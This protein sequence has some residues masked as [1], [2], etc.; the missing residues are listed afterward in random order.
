M[1]NCDH[2]RGHLADLAVLYLNLVAQEELSQN[3]P[4]RKKK[5]FPMKVTTRHMPSEEKHI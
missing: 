3:A 1:T 5:V 4:F 2:V